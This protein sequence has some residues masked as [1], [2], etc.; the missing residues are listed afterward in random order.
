MILHFERR[1]QPL[2]SR[3]AFAARVVRSGAVAATLVLVSVGLGTL[4]YRFIAHFNWVDS[5]LNACML[6]GGMGPVGDLPNDA[7]KIF[8]GLFALY[9]GLV[10]LIAA[11]VLM[12]PILHRVLHH[13][14]SDVPERGR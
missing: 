9:A 5:F 8:A 1:S 10:F 13:F 6:L 4:G 14:H 2:L 12:T 3:R 11:A 7:A